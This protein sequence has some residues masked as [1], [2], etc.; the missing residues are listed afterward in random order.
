LHPYFAIS[1]RDQI[2]IDGLKAAKFSDSYPDI[3]F[4]LNGSA[5]IER[6]YESNNLV[7]FYN[8]DYWITL[9]S[10]C[11]DNWM[12]WNPGEVG[13]ASIHDLPDEHWDKFICI[14]P[15]ITHPKTLAPGELFI[16]ELQIIVS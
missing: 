3:P 4:D 9:K 11:F 10:K 14:E 7:K 13:G 12:I 1:S 8:G 15:V 16:G 2:A 6:L 5:L